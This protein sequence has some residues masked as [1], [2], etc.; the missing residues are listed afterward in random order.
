MCDISN[1]FGKANCPDPVVKDNVMYS[2]HLV[3]IMTLYEAFSK[4]YS[5][6]LK[7]WTFYNEQYKIKKKPPSKYNLRKLVSTITLQN[8]QS[9]ISAFS[10]E[11]SIIY[12]VCNQHSVLGII[13]YDAIHNTNFSDAGNKK[14][15]F[16][17]IRFNGTHL[18]K[19]NKTNNLSNI[20]LKN[21]FYVGATQKNIEEII[22]IFP[23]IRKF[24]RETIKLYCKKSRENRVNGN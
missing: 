13:L 18:S 12:T 9:P 2:G 14:K 8:I 15:F 23:T 20:S 17:W 11:P 19:Y 5:L 6:S 3:Q 1:I 4:E 16:N 22:T 24:F 7:G 10:C 21:S